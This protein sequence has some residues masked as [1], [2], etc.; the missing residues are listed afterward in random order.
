MS[1]AKPVLSNS[2]SLLA[3]NCTMD[4]RKVEG[5]WN[6]L[7]WLCVL[8]EQGSFTAA[9]QRVGVSKAAMSEHIR[10]LERSVGVSLVRRTTRSVQLTEAGHRLVSDTR[11]QYQ[12]IAE[13]FASVRDSAGVARGLIRVTAPVAFARQQLVPHLSEFLHANPEVKIQLEVSDRLSS[14]T[15]EGFDLAIRH[16]ADV[17]ETHVAWTLCA[18]QSVIVATPQ[19]LQERS[20][21]SSP[22]DLRHHACLFYPRGQ[23]QPEWTFERRTNGALE[24]VTVPIDGPFAA[25]N[26]EALR[27]AALDGLG[28]TLL[29]DF[30]AQAA[31]R[32]GK[33]LSL[34]PEWQPTGTFAKQLYIVRPYVSH[35]P[36]AVA[37]FI[38]Y[39]RQRYAPGFAA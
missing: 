30:S 1:R 22:T 33:L 6:H 14:L 38:A 21:P 25:N 10:D 9:A 23:D 13:S 4:S 15:H 29:P 20:T 26:S 17:P 36:R 34:L 7:H 39:L 24:R 5:L 35:V 3:N 8:A 16:S 2:L 28:I 19:Y 18:T 31:L 37:V 32:S 12:Q 27:D 11:Q